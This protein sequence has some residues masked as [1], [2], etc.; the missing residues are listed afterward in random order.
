M[1]LRPLS[2]T[3][4]SAQPASNPMWDI[5]QPPATTPDRTL[6]KRPSY[7]ELKRK[8]S[9]F[10]GLKVPTE[11]AA[12]PVPPIPAGF[13]SES[14]ATWSTPVLPEEPSTPTPTPRSRL[15]APTAVPRSRIGRSSSGCPEVAEPG[16]F[17]SKNSKTKGSGLGRPAGPPRSAGEAPPRSLLRDVSTSTGVV[18]EAPAILPHTSS[19]FPQTSAVPAP[20]SVA[21]PRPT[22]APS[23]P[24]RVRI[25][26]VRIRTPYSVADIIN[27]EQ[28][29]AAALALADGPQSPGGDSPASPTTVKSPTSSGPAVKDVDPVAVDEILPAATPSATLPRSHASPRHAAKASQASQKSHAAKKLAGA[30]STTAPGSS[31]AVSGSHEDTLPKTPSPLRD[32]LTL[33]SDEEPDTWQRKFN[34]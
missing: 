26:G 7:H 33:E 8:A 34:S 9:Q 32:A 13:L 17:K 23:N 14:P 19:L 3:R 2:P 18:E 20:L 25:P 1:P 10:I 5:P 22:V 4:Q 27:A 21:S 29:H 12:P 16:S 28:R 6:Q 11:E 30:P 24:G 31:R 15:T